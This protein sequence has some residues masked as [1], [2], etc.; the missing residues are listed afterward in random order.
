MENL[1]R[2]FYALEGSVGTALFAFSQAQ[3]PHFTIY[4]DIMQK[5]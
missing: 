4:M 2:E 3:K 1:K 5:R